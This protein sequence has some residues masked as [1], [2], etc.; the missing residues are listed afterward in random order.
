MAY[1]GPTV[2]PSI[3]DTLV[4]ASGT[5]RH[6]VPPLIVTSRYM[7]NV[8]N[9]SVADLPLSPPHFLFPCI[10]VPPTKE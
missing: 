8:S 9:L 1:C 10:H 3:A 5:A 7:G 2:E 6:F 4:V